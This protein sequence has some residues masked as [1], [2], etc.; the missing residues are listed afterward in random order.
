VVPTF[1]PDA[2]VDPSRTSR[3]GELLDRLAVVSGTATGT[4]AGYI[5]ALES[6]RAFFKQLGAT[7]T[8]HGHFS[9][10]VVE[11]SPRQAA[12]LYQR[13]RLGSAGPG[14]AALFSAHMLMEMARMSADDGLVMQLHPGAWRDHDVATLARYGPD[15]GADFPVATSFTRALQPLLSRF[16][17]S[18]TFRLVAF[19]M[20]ET[21]YSRELAPMASYYPALWLGAPW[22]FLDSPDAMSRF[23][24]AV[25]ETAGFSRCA[26]FVDDTRAYCSIPARHDLARRAHCAF[27][28]R[29][30]SEH[31]LDEA[32]ASGLAADFAYNLPRSVFR[33]S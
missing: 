20:D 4:Y 12:D 18:N 27:L 26:G 14:D 16:G 28:A 3:W 6:R 30:V 15:L 29:L 8:D 19:T 21:V 11:L 24:S 31:R 25:T 10:D 13:L 17:N 23:W 1:R 2:L 5:E 33:A 22:W 7:A 9:S 32:D